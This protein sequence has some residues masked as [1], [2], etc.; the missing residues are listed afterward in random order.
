MLFYKVFRLNSHCQEALYIAKVLFYLNRNKQPSP[1]R[2]R[3]GTGDGL[4]H[5][6]AHFHG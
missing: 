5:I 4:L 2:V 3:I 1:F 6:L